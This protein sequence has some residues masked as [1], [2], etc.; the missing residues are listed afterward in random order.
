MVIYRHSMVILPFCVIK[1]INLLNYHGMAV[2]YH[3]IFETNDIKHNLTKMGVNYC[4]ILNLEKVGVYFSSNLPRYC[5][6]TLAFGANVI[7]LLW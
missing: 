5:F 6:I 1:L 2:N 4:G 3:G 7:K